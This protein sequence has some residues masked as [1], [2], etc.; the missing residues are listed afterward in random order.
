[1][2]IKCVIVVSLGCALTAK[3]CKKASVGARNVLDLD[4]DGGC[5]GVMICN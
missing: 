2:V 4:V 5:M 1:M 3:E